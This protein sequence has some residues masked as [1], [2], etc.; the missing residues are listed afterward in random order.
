MKSSAGADDGHLT[1]RYDTDL[2]LIFPPQWSPLQPPLSLAALAGW[3]RQAGFAV[4]LLDLNVEFYHWLLSDSGASCILD[5]APDDGTLLVARAIVRSASSF[6]RTV[7]LMSSHE[8]DATLFSRHFAAYRALETYLDAVSRLTDGE[9]IIRVS[10]MTLRNG[11]HTPADME[12]LI[13]DPHPVLGYYVDRCATAALSSSPSA[14]GLSC[15]GLE[16]LYFSLAIG[17]LVKER[18][19]ETIVI[20]GGTVLQRIYERGSLPVHWFGTYFDIVV[21]HEGERPAQK[22][23]EVIRDGG[24]LSTVPG[25]LFRSGSEVIETSPAAPLRPAEIP[26]PDFVG[27]DL[28]RY[29]SPELTL[30]LLASRGCYWGKCEFCHHGMVFG[31]RYSTQSAADVLAIVKRLA[32]A[33]GVRHFAFND[34]AV[35]PK[36]LRGIG[37]VFPPTAQSGLRFTG[38]IKFEKY[39]TV[40]DFE[41]ASNVGFKSLYIG[42]ESASERVLD[43]MR[44]SNSQETILRNLTDASAAGI[45]V[46]CFVFF[47]FPGETAVDAAETHDFMLA[48]SDII[49][50]FAAH[51]FDLEHNAPIA[52]KPGPHG[53]TIK[54]GES[55]QSLS[56]YY[57]YEVSE[58]LNQLEAAEWKQR[59]EADAANLSSYQSGRWIPRE[60][61]ISLLDAYGLEE[62]RSLG[63]QE[64]DAIQ[65]PNDLLVE[66]I[67][68]VDHESHIVIYMPTGRAIRVESEV[69]ELCQHVI[70]QGV[71][72]SELREW[73]PQ[74]ERILLGL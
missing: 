11:V 53:V 1:P 65:A 21:C 35:P 9:F 42:L 19:P 12:D 31:D 41:Q 32:K 47:G 37:E 4:E 50:S 20:V 13:R 74:V 29:L 70:E 26:D 61:L 51:V 48:H 43:L 22:V 55:E 60:H 46:H 64:S 39:F 27:L 33:Y 38:L 34:E 30:P 10:S 56:V 24:D 8:S 54:G 14:V 25:I 2:A 45:W 36:V 49:A 28:E 17:R 68:V 69:A 73:G 62:L 6:R 5:A 16:Q 58:G 23:L 63:K 71:R 40:K 66:D 72:C 67:C 18:A 15:I 7:G 44:K 3:L 59:L 57:D 52:R